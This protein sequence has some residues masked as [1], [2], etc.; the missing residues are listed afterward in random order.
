VDRVGKLKGKVMALVS[1]T[2]NDISNGVF[3]GRVEDDYQSNLPPYERYKWNGTGL[4]ST[5]DSVQM[6]LATFNA[7]PL[8]RRLALQ[9]T[10]IIDPVTGLVM[11]LAGDGYPRGVLAVSYVA[12]STSSA[13]ETV[14]YQLAIPGG[15]I[16]PNSALEIDT[17]NFVTANTNSKTFSIGIGPNLGSK[18]NFFGR[19]RTSA[20]HFGEV[21]RNVL[22]NRGVVNSQINPFG[23]SATYTSPVGAGPSTNT[24]DFSVDQVLFVT[25][26][27]AVGTD[28]CRLD[29]IKVSIV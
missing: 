15:I 4:V 27:C 24:Y 6:S 25:G 7:F 1:L 26:L 29:Y 2:A 17:E 16:G 20:G 12:L 10:T 19:T 22:A 3:I 14:L 18:V 23:A 13:V 21:A 8:S 28:V 9:G 11:T 5:G